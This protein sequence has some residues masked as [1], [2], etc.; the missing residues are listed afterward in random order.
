VGKGREY[1]TPARAKAMVLM[2]FMMVSDCWV[3]R[4]GN[5]Y[6]NIKRMIDYT[7]C[8]V[9][10]LDKLNILGYIRQG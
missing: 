4:E 9:K 5:T 1:E 8:P 2:R 10:T 7:S 3:E 6:L